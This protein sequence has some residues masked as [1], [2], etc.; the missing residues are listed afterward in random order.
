VAANLSPKATQELAR[1][2]ALVKE[3]KD[4]EKL[5]GLILDTALELTGAERG[6]LILVKPGVGI[7]IKAARNLRKEHIEHPRFQFSR[8]IIFETLKTGKPQIVED[9]KE[10]PGFSERA[11]VTALRL[12]SVACVPLKAAGNLQGVL[13]LDNRLKPGLFRAE[14]A[15]LLQAFADRAAEAIA[16]TT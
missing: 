12:A 9:A 11:S 4:V 8:G 10:D 2:S 14:H 3:E 16:A 5:F 7:D 1:V 15:T 13:Y 6:F